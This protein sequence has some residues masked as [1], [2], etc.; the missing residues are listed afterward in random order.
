M[1]VEGS[2]VEGAGAVQLSR[3]RRRLFGGKPYM[4]LPTNKWMLE[5]GVLLVTTW[6]KERGEREGGVEGRTSCDEGKKQGFLERE[7]LLLL[8]PLPLHTAL[9]LHS[10]VPVTKRVCARV[11]VRA[12]AREA[13][14]DREEKGKGGVLICVLCCT[15]TVLRAE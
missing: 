15:A 11:S 2:G 1:G 5:G 6:T 12:R 14:R 10:C 3:E 13:E 4:T 7:P 9:P 8:L